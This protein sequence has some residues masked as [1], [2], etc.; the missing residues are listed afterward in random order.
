[1]EP[2]YTKTV[3]EVFR[4]LFVQCV[5]EFSSVDLLQSCEYEICQTSKYDMPTWVPDLSRPRQAEY[6][7]H[8][9]AATSTWREVDF[10]GS[11][12]LLIT[13]LLVASITRVHYQSTAEK[14]W[15]WEEIL[16]RKTKTCYN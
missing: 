6:F 10:L 4:D 5:K 14:S 9:T 12:V 3:A 15:T 1:M 7:T 11:N 13:G 2:D 8:K 16:G